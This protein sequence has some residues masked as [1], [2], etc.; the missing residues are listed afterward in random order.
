M[1]MSRPRSRVICRSVCARRSMPPNCARCRGPPRGCGREPHERQR[2]HRL[3]RTA[4]AHQ[5]ED[6]PFA[7]SQPKETS[8]QD[9]MLGPMDSDR[10]R[11]E[12]SVMSA[13]SAVVQPV[14]QTV[15]QKVQPEDGQHDCETGKIAT[16]G[17]SVT[18][19]CASAS[20]RPQLG[21][22]AGHRGPHRTG[23]PR[24]GCP[25]RTGWCPARSRG[26][27]C[28]AGCVR[29]KCAPAPAHGLLPRG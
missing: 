18:M 8:G 9:R 25:A 29:R 10:L 26:S 14:A 4:F 28:W 21:V 20:M 2:G 5:P 7:D 27:R 24:P 23:P 6:L 15:A 1:P 3:A 17:A 13:P 16:C 22:G 11:T 19:V 12:S